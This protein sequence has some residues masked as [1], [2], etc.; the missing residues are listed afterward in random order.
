MNIFNIEGS[1]ALVIIAMSCI[2]RK[3]GNGM[4]GNYIS[5]FI[6]NEILQAKAA[7]F[8]TQALFMQVTKYQM[9]V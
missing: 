9:Y 5:D 6:S 7:D 8:F 4:F 1:K 3:D 2:S